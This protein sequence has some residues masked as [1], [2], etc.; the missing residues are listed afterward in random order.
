MT[1]VDDKEIIIPWKYPW[2][3]ITLIA[4]T[5]ITGL[6]LCFTIGFCYYRRW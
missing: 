2:Y 1:Y 5:A 6:G 4:L 3:A